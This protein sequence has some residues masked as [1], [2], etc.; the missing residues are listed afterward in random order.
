MVDHTWASGA[1]PSA[2]LNSLR[3]TVTG[4]EPIIEPREYANPEWRWWMPWRPR[5]VVKNV[6]T[7]TRVR[8]REGVSQVRGY[9]TGRILIVA[10]SGL[11][12]RILDSGKDTLSVDSIPGYDAEPGDAYVV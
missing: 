9:Y 2:A 7:G 8:L 4:T 10:S 5:H 1:V 3:V 6:R 12:F 11:A